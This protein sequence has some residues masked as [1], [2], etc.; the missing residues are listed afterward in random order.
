[1]IVVFLD[2]ASFRVVDAVVVVAVAVAAAVFFA[3]AA[4]A[5]PS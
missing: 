5:L 1:M 2:A 3:C 4:L